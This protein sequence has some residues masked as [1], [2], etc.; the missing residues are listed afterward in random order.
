MIYTSLES[1][2]LC[3]S[4]LTSPTS[5]AEEHGFVRWGGMGNV[6]DYWLKV[7][8]REISQENPDTTSPGQI[9][10]VSTGFWL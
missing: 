5:V 3:F 6:Q 8:K 9:A 7:L 4:Q 2:P 1:G 10:E